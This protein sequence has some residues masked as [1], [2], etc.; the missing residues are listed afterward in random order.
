MTFISV[1]PNV[2]WFWVIQTK[3][4]LKLRCAVSQVCTFNFFIVQY[5]YIWLNFGEVHYKILFCP[6]NVKAGVQKQENSSD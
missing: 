1:W 5:T 6:K 2:C 3:I 4:L